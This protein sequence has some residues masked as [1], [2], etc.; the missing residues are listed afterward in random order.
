MAAHLDCPAAIA[1]PCLPIDVIWALFGA[2]GLHAVSAGKRSFG[3]EK[4]PSPGIKT[5]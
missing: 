2:G 3:F 5:K 4:W 1:S